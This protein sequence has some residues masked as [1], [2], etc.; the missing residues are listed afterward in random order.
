MR[1][2]LPALVLT[3]LLFAPV[4]HAVAQQPASVASVNSDSGR[5]STPEAQSPE[6][7]Q[8]E[9]DE[10]DEYRHSATVRAL[11]AKLGMNA[12]QAATAFT[13]TN[14]IVLAILVGWFLLKT[15]PKTFRDRS[16]AIQKHLVDA[17]TATE[18]ASARLNSVENR[19]G[20][21]DEQIAAM[22]VQAEKDAALDEQRIKAAVEEEKQK[23]LKSAE[24]EISAATSQA[25]KHLQQY[26][27]EL[28]I[29]QAARKLV[30]TAETDRLL[31]QGFARRLTGDE[32]KGGEN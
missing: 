5:M 10:N 17:R 2:L 16:S 19:L 20:K 12:D 28:A 26:A 24:Q 1:K 29:E 23:I 3:T 27:A 25:R 8:Q 18:E 11:G 32:T 14:F 6:K 31:V 30:V 22:R 21:L 13:V 9:K 7:N 15:L 4:C